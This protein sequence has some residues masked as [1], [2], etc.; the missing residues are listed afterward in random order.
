[1]ITHQSH[2]EPL[3][4]DLC[5]KP[6]LPWKLPP[7]VPPN[8]QFPFPFLGRGRGMNIFWNYTLHLP[9][10]DRKGKK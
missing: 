6:P 9:I 4:K 3:E 7:F 2:S 1:M 10:L 5:S 8:P